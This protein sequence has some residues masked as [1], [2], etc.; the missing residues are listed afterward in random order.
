VIE[1]DFR[2]VF[3]KGYSAPLAVP[4]QSPGRA[5][6]QVLAEQMYAWNWHYY[7]TYGGAAGSEAVVIDCGAAE[8][9][10]SFLMQRQARRILCI[11]PN[12]MYVAALRRTFAQNCD[13]SIRPLAVGKTCGTAYLDEADIRSQLNDRALGFEVKVTTIDEIC[14]AE[15]ISPT[16][17]KADIEGSEYDMIAGAAATIT[18]CC[19]GLAVT[20][21]HRAGDAAR[22][23]SLL[24]SLNPRYK[25]RLSGVESRWGDPV[26]LHAYV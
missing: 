8:G 2:L 25:I 16:L 19:P 10:F 3:L 24:R 20:T 21:Y 13:V 18:R 6:N 4:L 14:K 5:L 7:R 22:I 11:E 26:M 1:G 9:L 17:I 12:P 15:C 23:A